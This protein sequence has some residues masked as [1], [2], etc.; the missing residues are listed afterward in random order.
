MIKQLTI[1]AGGGIDNHDFSR[2]TLRG[3]LHLEREAM[4]S[5]ELVKRLHEYIVKPDSQS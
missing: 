2:P 4:Q 5:E 3:Q 1:V